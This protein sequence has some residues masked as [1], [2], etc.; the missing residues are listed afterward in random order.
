MRDD[1]SAARLPHRVD[2]SQLCGLPAED[3]ANPNDC[4]QL[5]PSRNASDDSAR[6]PLS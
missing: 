5:T 4:S 2:H 1:P 3:T 6:S